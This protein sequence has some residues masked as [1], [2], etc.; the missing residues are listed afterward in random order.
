MG[1]SVAQLVEQRTENPCVDGSIPPRTTSRNK[2]RFRRG[3]FFNF[4]LNQLD[5]EHGLKI[6][7]A[8]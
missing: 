6:K 3:L 5:A 7:G 2:P 1:G 4:Y 8:E